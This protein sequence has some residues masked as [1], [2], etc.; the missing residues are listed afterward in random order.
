VD[1][2][3]AASEAAVGVAGFGLALV[4]C[5]GWHAL[6]QQLVETGQVVAR[7]E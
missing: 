3:V 6:Q 1:A 7:A 2:P 5:L 4:P